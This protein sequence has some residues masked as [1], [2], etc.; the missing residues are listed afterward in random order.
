[1][2]PLPIFVQLLQVTE[3]Q[4]APAGHGS[5]CRVMQFSESLEESVQAIGS[6]SVSRSTSQALGSLR[7]SCQSSR[8]EGVFGFPDLLVVLF[9]RCPGWCV[10]PARGCCSLTGAWGC[11]RRSGSSSLGVFSAPSCFSLFPLRRLKRIRRFIGLETAQG[12]NP[13]TGKVALRPVSALGRDP[14][15]TSETDNTVPSTRNFII[16]T[17]DHV[18]EMRNNAFVG[19]SAHVDTEIGLAASEGLGR[20]EFGQTSSLGS[21]FCSS[22]LVTARPARIK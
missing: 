3:Q 14:G 19:N 9:R 8:L 7:T 5:D 1:M 10:S 16:N 15:I 17:L 13:R 21:S 11:W 20:H 18:K 12:A 2:A 22:P 6:T 4:R